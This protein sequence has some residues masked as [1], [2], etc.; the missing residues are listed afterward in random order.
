MRKIIFIVLFFPSMLLLFTGCQDNDNKSNSSNIDVN[1]TSTSISNTT[2]IDNQNPVV[3]T[4]PESNEAPNPNNETKE[5][6]NNNGNNSE[7][8]TVEPQNNNE[9]NSENA[10]I[11][12]P[13]NT[14]TIASEFTTQIKTKSK[15]RATNISLTCSKINET[16]V[17]PGEEFSFCG[18]I[19]VSKE[20]DGY[21]KADV[22]VDK[23]VIQALGGGN[24]QVST[25]LF[26]AVLG[27]ADLKVTERHPHGKK[28]NYVPEGKD[29]AI[30]HGSKDF[31]F[32]NN[33]SKSLKIY[34][35]SDGK[36]VHIKLVYI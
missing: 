24:C 21:K 35:D 36:Q 30:A 19:G 5:P 8:P 12:P 28:V 14:E 3:N 22:I 2:A 13:Q 15:N 6:Q 25:T 18:K 26:N 20:S 17:K 23:K 4:N 1:R 7:N 29:A 11:D 16:I 32:K 33:S 34:A 31:K 10:N 27:A 9:N